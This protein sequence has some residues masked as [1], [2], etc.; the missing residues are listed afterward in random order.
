M[1][2][3][4]DL[5]VPNGQSL[6]VAT[7]ALTKALR[8]GR[9]LEALYWAQQIEARYPWLL[10][11]RLGVFAAEDIG[12]ADPQAVTVVASVR[13]LYEQAK[14]ESRAPRPDAALLAFTVQYLARTPKCR[15]ADDLAA[16]LEHLQDEEGWS[17]HV[18]AEAYDLHTSQGRA[19]MTRTERL[20]HWLTEA[21]RL[22]PDNG[23]KDWALWVHRWAA[24][25]GALDRTHVE[26]QA[27]VWDQEGRLRYGTKGYPRRPEW[28]R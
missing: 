24:R 22:L 1:T 9:E 25:R 3:R 13:Q 17:P 26:T 19:L 23:P 18:P 16:A 21:T 15:E 6:A 12:I 8:R 28:D 4:D 27:Q 2:S 7:S 5:L 11:R 14:K 20:T 10:F